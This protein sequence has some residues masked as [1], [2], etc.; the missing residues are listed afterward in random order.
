MS[1]IALPIR[2]FWKAAICLAGMLLLVVGWSSIASAKLIAQTAQEG[3]LIF[4]QRCTSCH[5]IGGGT[6]VGP[7]LQGVTARRDLAWLQQFILA[8]DKMIAAGDPIVLELMATH[9]NIPMPNLGL[10][11]TEVDAVIAYLESAGSAAP[12]AP[13]APA[14]PAAVTGDAARGQMLFSGGLALQNGGINCIA[15]H[16]VRTTAG[17]GG[18][19]LGPDLT[20]VYTRYGGDAGLS[21]VLTTLP[22][23]NM[24]STFATRPLT[25]QE[26]AD[27]LAYFRGSSQ[28]VAGDVPQRSGLFVGVAAVGALILFG[29]MALFWPL[30]RTSLSNKLRKQSQ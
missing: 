12:A 25:P 2:P 11:P 1:R 15:C 13:A 26:Q 9:N 19:T 14:Q 16:H 5:T 10:T 17:L 29:M 23:P 21:A 4:N 20:Q 3:E 22:F 30:Q 8:P 28:V 24:Q 7:D 6:L 27:L 18:G